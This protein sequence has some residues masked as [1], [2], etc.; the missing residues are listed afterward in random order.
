MNPKTAS[1]VVESTPP[2]SVAWFEAVDVHPEMRGAS[3]PVLEPSCEMMALPECTFELALT[4][5]RPVVSHAIDVA[6]KS[7]T[8]ALVPHRAGV[9]REEVF[10]GIVTDDLLVALPDVLRTAKL[11]RSLIETPVE[12][13]PSAASAD[14]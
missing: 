8:A 6:V 13:P 9:R 2:E 1:S 3:D 4:G 5:D 14:H 7:A 12:E 11:S 10:E